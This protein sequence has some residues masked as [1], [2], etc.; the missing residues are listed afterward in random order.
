MASVKSL[1]VHQPAG[2]QHAIAEQLLPPEPQPNLYT[3]EFYPDTHYD[4]TGSEVQGEDELVTT[5]NCVIWSRGGVF[6]KSFRFE[7]E[8]EPIT[9]ALLAYFPTSEDDQDAKTRGD[10]NKSG[11]TRAMSKA[12]VVFLKSQAHIY[13]L[14]GTSHV[15]HMPF[16]VESA[17]AAPCGVIIQ[18][19]SRKDNLAPVT[20]KFPRVPPN[21]FVSSQISPVSH[22][23][24][25]A[26]TTFSTE[27]LGK[28]RT[29]PLRLS[30][31]L[32]NMW[33][34]PLETT[35][36]HWPRLVCLTDPLLELGLVVHQPDRPNNEAQGRG[37]SHSPFLDPA[38][39]ILHVEAVRHPRQA[40]G[41]A[42]D[43]VILA[44]T[45]NRETNMY[46]VWRLTYIENEDYFVA[47]KKKKPK[48]N[49]ARRRSS[50]QPGL[51]SGAATPLPPSF[52][53]SLG[54]PLP[55]KKQRKSEKP[56]KGL[57]NIAKSLED[58]GGEVTRRQS[59]RVS[60]L[61][62]RADLSAS[63]ERSAFAEQ[64]SSS[65]HP[66][67]KRVDS[68]SGQR[69]RV[70]S[71]FGPGSLS[72]TYP[73]NLN[74]L[75]AA[76]VND[77]LDELRAGG[78]FEGFPSLGLD[79]HH[80]DGLKREML[81]T[82]IREVPMDNANVR[83]SLSD[84]PARLQCKVYIVVGPP[85]AVDDE[86]RNQVMVCIQ[87]QLDKKLLIL[88]LHTQNQSA[89]VWDPQAANRAAP[90]EKEMIKVTFGDLRRAQNVVGSCRVFDGDQSV[91]L[92]LSNNMA[93]Q[94]E[95]SIQAPWS[96]LTS[97]SLPLL[98]Y[99]NLN[100]LDYN[101]SHV[102]R[103][104]RNR[105]SIGIGFSGS[106]INAVCHGQSGGVVDIQDRD[107]KFHQ[108]QIQ[109]QPKVFQVRK[110]LDTCRSIL[111]SSHAEGML[112]GWWHVMQ[113]LGEQDI[114][115][116][117]SEWSS[118]VILLFATFFG[119][120]H[121]NVSTW[122]TGTVQQHL[123][124]AES[125]SPGREISKFD[126]MQMFEAP[127][128]SAYPS[129]MQDRAWQWL[130]DEPSADDMNVNDGSRLSFISKHIRLAKRYMASS[131]AALAISPGGY[132]PTAVSKKD[133]V[134]DL[135]DAKS[136][137]KR[138]IDAAWS[139]ASA[140]HLLLEEQKLDTMSPEFLSPGQADLRVVMCQISR[141]LCWY[142][143]A[144]HYAMGMQAEV[145][146]R[147]DTGMNSID[148]FR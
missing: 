29:L 105:R 100:S 8:K 131:A 120:A 12:L 104:V 142:D 98:Y 32:E 87:D 107:G 79:D 132:L 49:A 43:G 89:S 41:S 128:S 130:L 15:V 143:L 113:W 95:L 76:P 21:S 116:A 136:K 92:I 102:N 126:Q 81:F 137:D 72:G 145:D 50:M 139:I 6:R 77:L 19:K 124:P 122:E 63:H 73:R 97:I 103:E 129:W 64:S 146:P 62:A 133:D 114:M 60:S 68:H 82:K 4:A 46:T 88:G 36:S 55:G 138:R 147:D 71:G 20:L 69:G 110:V 148:L 42:L 91:I 26:T 3:W 56:E 117:N 53:E 111:L 2:L 83:Y 13:F 125:R 141:W 94:R 99:H 54:A 14:A 67:G 58:K 59:R 123:Q 33:D 121:S 78:D 93:D 48:K 101:G 37:S 61:L 25:Q 9:Q 7:L 11:G 18:R 135:K 44:V 51:N 144:S 134:R 1:G 86:G 27:G 140:L 119:L 57:D 96:H 108:I 34:A 31:T 40:A 5:R 38:E 28:P 109:L 118:L 106:H 35:D 90:A 74:S 115:V 65:A 16:E 127:N 85:F 80:F 52:R 39:E 24:M 112:A 30:S 66:G 84:K 75:R 47:K 23:T 17:C 70:S 22:R 45:A 10:R